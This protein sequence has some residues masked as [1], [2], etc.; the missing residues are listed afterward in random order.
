[1]RKYVEKLGE[2]QTNWGNLCNKMV[3]YKSASK[4]KI[5]VGMSWYVLRVTMD[6]FLYVA[7]CTGLGSE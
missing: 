1:M 2:M 4:W 3:E 5:A 7:T 6:L